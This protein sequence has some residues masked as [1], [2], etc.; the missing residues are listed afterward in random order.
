M[1][2]GL[3]IAGLIIGLGAL[4]AGFYAFY[5]RQIYLALQFCYKLH[6]ITPI[7]F[8]KNKVELKILLKILNRSSFDINLT[9]Y[10]FDVYMNSIKLTHIKSNKENKILPNSSS[11]IEL[12][13]VINPK[14]VF[15]TS[16]WVKIFEYFITDTS[17]VIIKV[18]GQL[19]AKLNFISMKNLPVTYESSMKELMKPADPATE[20]EKLKCPKNF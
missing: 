2:K 10:D 8:S 5:R 18:T 17:K 4:A 9:G 11:I 20:A 12:Y 1:K 7:T 14:E 19:S 15:S 3:I 6:Q 16:E 13:V